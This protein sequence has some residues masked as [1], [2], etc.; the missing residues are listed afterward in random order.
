MMDTAISRNEAQCLKGDD[1]HTQFL[2][3]EENSSLPTEDAIQNRPRLS[4]SPTKLSRP[5]DTEFLVAIGK[6]AGLFHTRDDDAWASVK[7]GSCMASYPIEGRRFREWLTK[8]AYRETGCPPTPQAVESAIA[9]LAAI[10]KFDSQVADVHL[11][12]CRHDG[13]VWVDLANENGEAV[14]IDETG[15]SIV[16]QPPIRF[17]RPEGML[18]FPQPEAGANFQEFRQCINV[19]DEFDFA[20]LGAWMVGA[21]NPDGPFPLLVIHGP[22]G[23]GKSTLCR[24]LRSLIDPNTVSSRA[25]PRDERDLQIA[26]RNNWVLLFDNV[27]GITDSKADQLCRMAT[28][29]GFATRKLYNDCDEVR[30]NASRPIVLNGIAEFSTRP[31]LLDRFLWV[32]LKAFGPSGRDTE[33]VLNGNVRKIEGRLLGSI[34]TAVS[35]AL[36]RNSSVPKSGLPRMIDFATWAIAAEKALGFSEGTMRRM[37]SANTKQNEDWVVDGNPIVDSLCTL[38]SKENNWAGNSTELYS[39]LASLL[40]PTVTISKS[41]PKDARGLSQ[42]LKRLEPTLQSL[43]VSVERSRSSSERTIIVSKITNVE[44]ALETGKDDG[45]D[46]DDERCRSFPL[47]KKYEE[48][49]TTM[50]PVR[51]AS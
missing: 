49:K 23:S 45:N 21:F 24:H 39:K 41:W 1:G 30:F 40:D 17:Y 51:A 14:R 48:L 31:D 9:T 16:A 3:I 44:V 12:V 32:K 42:Q 33:S 20:A 2:P 43:G 25:L 5:G 28:G 4:M 22:Q 47:L 7:D 38:I 34:F 13:A 35:H 15:W 27:S 8:G 6:R 46:D 36:K 26:A 10:A 19:E 11:R 50:G 18:S 29:S 37:L